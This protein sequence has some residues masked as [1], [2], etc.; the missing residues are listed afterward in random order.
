MAKRTIEKKSNNNFTKDGKAK[1][2]II[3]K[4]L[5]EQL[6]WSRFT[7]K[8]IIAIANLI[9]DVNPNANEIEPLVMTAKEFNDKCCFKSNFGTQNMN[10]LLLS[11]QS[12]TFSVLTPKD[13]N[14][15]SNI[16]EE[17]NKEKSL[18]EESGFEIS[19]TSLSERTDQSYSFL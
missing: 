5:A 6:N 9:A 4:Y 2:F 8:E 15:D 16:V 10:D 19:S 1:T 12:K 17:Y 11:I 13:Y 14:P 18:N 3:G 7:Y